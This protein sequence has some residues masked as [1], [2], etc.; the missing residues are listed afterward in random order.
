MCDDVCDEPKNAHM[1]TKNKATA[2]DIAFKNNPNDTQNKATAIDIAFKMN[3]MCAKMNTT[4]MC[5]VCRICVK[6]CVA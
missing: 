3:T 1:S 6:T 5:D 4:N 2:I